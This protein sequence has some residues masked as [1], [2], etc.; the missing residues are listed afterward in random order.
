M[1]NYYHFIKSPIKTKKY[2]ALFNDGS[3]VDFGARFYTQYEDKA[4]GLYSNYNNLD[5]K[6]RENYYKRHNIDYP[7]YSADWFSKKYLW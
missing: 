3:Y 1:P 7:K 4:L 2:R 6:K 5:K